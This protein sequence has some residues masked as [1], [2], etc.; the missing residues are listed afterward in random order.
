MSLVDELAKLEEL[1]RR[2]ALS[3]SEFA[4]AKAALLHGAPA[5]SEPGLVGHLAHQVAEL[6]YQ[7]QLAQ[8]D[9]EWQI[10]RL[11]FDL[12]PRQYGTPRVPTAGMG[13]ATAIVG[14]LFGVFWTIMSIA[15]TSGAPDSGAVFAAKVF[16]PLFGV[17]F[18][19]GAIGVGMYY[20]AKAQ[21]YQE[22][23]AAYQARRARAKPEQATAADRPR[24]HGD[25]RDKIK[26]A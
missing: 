8:I 14:G 16:Y 13:I 17:V 21:K 22:A 9:R 2:G 4:Q 5:S 11:R 25:N 15:I 26:P 6:Q 19:G 3:E 12:Y 1:R 7:N 23:L 18:T 10:E 24:E 20:Y